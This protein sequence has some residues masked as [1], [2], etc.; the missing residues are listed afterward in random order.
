[1]TALADRALVGWARWASG[2]LFTFGLLA[3]FRGRFGGFTDPQGISVLGFLA[4]PLTS[5]IHLVVAIAMI[6]A[7][8]SLAAVARSA[9]VV[10]PL[11]TVFGLLE[12][13]LGDGSADVFGRNDRMALVDL[14]VGVTG[15]AVWAWSRSAARA[16]RGTN[17]AGTDVSPG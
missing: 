2:V 13:A 8:G 10:G 17:D 9:L 3:I 4:S 15:I 16:A 11:F 6:A 5:V 1:M 14:A 12:F 7:L